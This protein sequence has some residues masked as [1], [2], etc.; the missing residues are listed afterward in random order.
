[1]TRGYDV[2]SVNRSGRPASLSGQWVDDTLWIAAD[3]FDEDAW[4]YC[5]QGACARSPGAEIRG[6]S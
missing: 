6:A 5:L 1:M 2:V 3:V 4:A